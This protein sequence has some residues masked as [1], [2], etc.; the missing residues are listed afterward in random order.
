[1]TFRAK[2]YNLLSTFRIMVL[3]IFNMVTEHPTFLS[4]T[5]ENTALITSWSFLVQRIF[6]SCSLSVTEQA[7]IRRDFFHFFS[8]SSER[9]IGK[10]PKS[11][12]LRVL[13][14][15]GHFGRYEL[16]LSLHLEQRSFFPSIFLPHSLQIPL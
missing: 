8:F 1:M 7:L 11:S 9:L 14:Q 6:L 2:S 10:H 3:F 15:T 13:P 5:Y 12:K 4:F 16:Y